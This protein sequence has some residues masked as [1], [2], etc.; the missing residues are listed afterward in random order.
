MRPTWNFWLLVSTRPKAGCYSHLGSEQAD[1]RSLSFCV[2][3]SLTLSSE[4]MNLFKKLFE[5]KTQRR[6]SHLLRPIL[7]YLQYPRQGEL[8]A[9]NWELSI[10]LPCVG[11]EP[12]FLGHHCCFPRSIWA[13][14][15][16]QD[17]TRHPDTGHEYLYWSPNCCI[18]NLSQSFDSLISLKFI[19]RKVIACWEWDQTES[20]SQWPQRWRKPIWRGN[21]SVF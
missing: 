9:R 3:L 10:G 15:W 1:E 7:K 2:F 4:Y 11:Q 6:S 19:Y 16:N 12:T 13:G 5:I 17:Q 21:F 18:I 8:G 20:S 14:N